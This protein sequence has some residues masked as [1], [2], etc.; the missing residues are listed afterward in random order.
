MTT[1][2]PGSRETFREEAI[3]PNSTK[4]T[5]KGELQEPSEESSGP[6]DSVRLTSFRCPKC[7][8]LY[9]NDLNLETHL[10]VAHGRPSS[11]VSGGVEKPRMIH[12]QG[13]R[14]FR[15]FRTYQ[16]YLEHKGTHS[17]LARLPATKKPYKQAVRP[18]LHECT[19]GGCKQAFAK[20]LDL[21]R[22]ARVHSGDKPFECTHCNMGFTQKYRLTTH[23]RGHTG[24]K[25]FS[26]KFCE[27]TFTRGDA[28]QSHVSK[29][30]AVF[31][32][33]L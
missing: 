6:S 17:E 13:Y 25:P 24:E 8:K 11:G 4:C 14:C 20:E 27:K 18:K 31:G 9:L 32:H 1:G 26:C 3:V 22:H 21:Q 23:L 15:T 5:H 2:G 16:D 7:T 19:Y 30:H 12:C 28:L 10:D 33:I 29:I